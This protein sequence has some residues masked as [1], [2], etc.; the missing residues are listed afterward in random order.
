VAVT[1]TKRTTHRSSKGRKLYAVKR[2]DGT[3]A[4]IQ[5][6]K[7]MEAKQRHC[8]RIAKRFSGAMKRLADE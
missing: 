6:Y 1:A 2:E 8:E 3:H 5:T 7:K 4:D